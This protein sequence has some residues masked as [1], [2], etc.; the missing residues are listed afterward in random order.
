M[1]TLSSRKPK[2]TVRMTFDLEA[3]VPTIT[4]TYGNGSALTL[5]GP[6]PSLRKQAWTI[7]YTLIQTGEWA[8]FPPELCGML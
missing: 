5:S 1:S 8:T 6:V 2:P 7:A 4:V 3:F